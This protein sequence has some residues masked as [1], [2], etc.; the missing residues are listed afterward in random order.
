M[1]YNFDEIIN[2]RDTNCMKWDGAQ[3]LKKMGITDRFDEE[4]IS[5]YTADMDFRCP[6]P[7]IDAVT[8]VAQHGIYGYSFLKPEHSY[9]DSV[10][11]WFAKYGWQINREEICAIQGTLAGI[12]AAIRTFTKPGENVIILTPVY[13]VFQFVIQ[14]AG[15]GITYCRLLSD[16]EGYSTIDYDLLEELASREENTAVLFCNPQNPTGRIWTREELEKVVAICK[17][18]DLYIF[19]DEVHCDL[20][21]CGLQYNPMGVAAAGYEKLLVFTAPNKTFNLAGF[22]VCNV[23]IPDPQVR[24]LFMNEMGFSFVSQFGIAACQSAYDD[25]G[26]WLEQVKEYIDGNMDWSLAYLK[27]HLPRVKCWRPEATY[28]L[29]MDFGAYGLSE[30]ELAHKIMQEANVILEG[31]VMFDPEGGQR[32]MRI[33]LPSSRQVIEEAFRRISAV[34]GDEAAY[35]RENVC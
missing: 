28:C 12:G 18:H 11:S 15:R 9:Y 5:V 31:G 33:C 26:D 8:K 7:V 25:G 14:S 2:R 10:A 29:W 20:V 3:W 13:G 1:K 35:E 6:Q 19:S 32:F 21:R 24:G 16:E 22:Q 4:T 23:V 17:K 27:E 30:A 34:F